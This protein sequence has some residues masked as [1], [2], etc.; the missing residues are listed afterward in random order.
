MNVSKFNY[1]L[2]EASEQNS[3]SYSIIVTDNNYAFLIGF[4]TQT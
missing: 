2:K 4:D 1:E 3:L